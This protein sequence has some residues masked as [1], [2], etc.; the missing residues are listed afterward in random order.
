MGWLPDYPDFRDYTFE[1][2]EILEEKIKE[3]IQELLSPIG[4]E[5]IDITALPSSVDL[6]YWCSKIEDQGQIGSCTAN[7]GAGVVEYFE[8]RAFGKYLDVSRLF[9]YKTTRNFA[10]LSGDSGAF[11]RNTMGALVLFGVPPEEY[12]PYTDRILGGHAVVAVGYNDSIIIKNPTCCNTTQG[13]LLIRNSWGEGWGDKGYGWLPYEYIRK[14]AALD[15]WSLLSQNWV[16]TGKF[17]I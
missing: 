2:K 1:T 6:R 7:A 11:L 17:K 12:W 3:N 10:I 8:N 5:K 13:A 14:E 15:F 16:D 9:L 4:L